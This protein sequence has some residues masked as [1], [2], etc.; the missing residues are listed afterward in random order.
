VAELT[1]PIFPACVQAIERTLHSFGYSQ[2]LST[3]RLGRL[4]EQASIDLLKQ[5]GACA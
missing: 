2:L 4:A 3:R 5:H 1:N